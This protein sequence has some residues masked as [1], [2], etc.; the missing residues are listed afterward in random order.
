MLNHRLYFKMT[1]T[2]FVYNEIELRHCLTSKSETK[3]IHIAVL[4]RYYTYHRIRDIASYTVSLHQR[5]RRHVTMM[6]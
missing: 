3:R 5:Q 2:N 6:M 4:Y 1:T